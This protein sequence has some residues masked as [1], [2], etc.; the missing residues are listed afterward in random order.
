LW[1]AVRAYS[2]FQIRP[3]KAIRNRLVDVWL[4]GSG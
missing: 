4:S 2:N 1:I 3:A